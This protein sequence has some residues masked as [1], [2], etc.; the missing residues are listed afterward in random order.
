[1]KFFKKIFL[2][3]VMYATRLIN[4]LYIL[5]IIGVIACGIFLCFYEPPF[6][7][8]FNHNTVTNR[9]YIGSGLLLIFLGPFVCR[10]IAEI[11]IVSF[12]INEQVAI[13]ADLSNK[14]KK[15]N[16]L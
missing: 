7:P 1:M 13:L 2:V 10:F 16:I 11:Y 4:I 5:S 3:D 8:R 15:Q 14:E 12:K 6:V 9:P